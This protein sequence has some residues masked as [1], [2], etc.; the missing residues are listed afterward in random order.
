VL[1]GSSGEFSA[2]AITGVSFTGNGVALTA[3][4]ASNISSGTLSAQYGGTGSANLTAE[5]VILGN[6]AN[7][8]KVVAPGTANNVLTSNGTTWISQA[9]TG[10]GGGVTQ[11]VAG[12]NITISPAGGTG[13]VTINSS[14]GG[15]GGSTGFEQTFLLMGA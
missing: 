9:P 12:T 13:A 8:V 14:G 3:I 11:I 10:G 6:G 5:N 7:T 15:G 4:N 1:R 2:G